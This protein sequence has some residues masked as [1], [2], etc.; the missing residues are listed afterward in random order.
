MSVEIHNITVSSH[1]LP[2]ENEGGD[3]LHGKIEDFE[4]IIVKV[5]DSDGEVGTGYTYTLGSGAASIQNLILG[6]ISNA[7]VGKDPIRLEDCW[8]TMSRSVDFLGRGGV[9][10]FALSAVDIALWDLNARRAGIPL[11]KYA[12]GARERVNIYFGGLDLDHSNDE[13]LAEL[14]RALS[15]GY[16]AVKLKVGSEDLRRDIKRVEIARDHLGPDIELMADANCAWNR[17]QAL[18]AL[19]HLEEYDLLWVEEPVAPEERDSYVFLREHTAVPIAGGE[20]LHTL[21]DFRAFIEKQCVDIVQ[22]DLTNCG[23]LTV[24][25]KIAVLAETTGTSIASHGA[26]DISAHAIAAVSGS[27][28]E[29]HPIGIDS[30]IESPLHPI[31]G[32]IQLGNSPGHGITFATFLKED[33]K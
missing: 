25:K 5:T 19:K 28:V 14:D 31:N 32:Q 22:P 15:L 21:S 8:S 24:F 29:R 11:W 30:L 2:V 9:A 12:G 4:L 13:L 1:L 20:N 33:Y 10:A 6:P 23:G 3:A 18:T 17:S 26:H 16:K 27:Y 7:L